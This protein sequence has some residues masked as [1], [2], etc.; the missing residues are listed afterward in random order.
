[1]AKRF[2]QV[3]GGLAFWSDLFVHARRLLR[4]ADELPKPNGQRLR[5]Y[6]DAQLPALRQM[7]LSSAPIYD[8]LEI[9]TLTHSLGR[10]REELGPDDALVKRVLGKESPREVATKLVK[11]S[12]LKKVESRKA[13]LDGG[14]TA[15]DASKDPMVEVARAVDA[16]AR[17]LRKIYEDTVE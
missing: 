3:E 8:E 1:M 17:A 5:E 15:V 12:H 9:L 4:A 6:T 11:G 13:L 7:E 16:D 14:K 10:M 2:Q